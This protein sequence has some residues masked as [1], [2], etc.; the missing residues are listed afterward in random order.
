MRIREC[1]HMN[2]VVVSC[3]FPPE[4]IV[5]AK[6]SYDIAAE[7]VRNGHS[8]TVIT[9]FPNRPGGRLLPGY[10]RKLFDRTIFH[11]EIKLI[12][13]A[14]YI[15]D[16]S[17]MF[18]RL[19]ENISFGLTSAAALLRVRKPDVIYANTWPIFATLL[20]VLISTMRRIPLVINV[21]DVYP[22]SMV[23]QKRIAENS[24]IV[25]WLRKIDCFIARHSKAVIVITEYFANIYIKSR[26]VL[27]TRLF[28]VPNWIDTESIRTIERREL[29]K[30][31]LTHGI[32][33]ENVLFVYGGNI[34]F[35]SGIDTVVQSF[36]LLEEN[37]PARLIVA[38]EGTQLKECKKIVDD[39]KNTC[40]TFH[41][42]WMQTE[43]EQVLQ[44]AQI[45]ILPTRGRQSFSSVPS[46]LLSYW[47]SARPVLAMALQG[48]ELANMIEIS[49][50][51]WV[52]PPDRPD[53]LLLK[54]REI[55]KLDT[56]RLLEM[57]KKGR[58]YVLMNYSKSHCLPKVVNVLE[59]VVSSKVD[60]Y[61]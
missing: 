42:P 17:S 37:S 6:T 53:L 1:E 18:S 8:V 3:V 49:G 55:L 35:A 4:P 58:E 36:M 19:F 9:S 22:E 56:D 23:S 16:D 27:S 7:L 46:K 39:A 33:A 26:N 25:V 2:F 13:C 30:Y 54:I 14:S 50:G 12:R 34:G 5:S 52:I 45:L 11:P 24:I 48:S 59:K 43:T 31:R 44:A 60:M 40:I 47:A 38:G 32:L 20:I 28:V 21:Q 10:R 61:S 29:S 51:G 41:S 15:S 57:G